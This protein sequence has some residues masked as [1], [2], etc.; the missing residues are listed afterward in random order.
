[1]HVL[2]RK[3]EH[4]EKRQAVDESGRGPKSRVNFYFLSARC[5]L[6]VQ[7]NQTYI[8]YAIQISRKNF[9]ATVLD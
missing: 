8:R 6:R 7:V 9:S 5:T 3:T 1:M 2:F 4:T